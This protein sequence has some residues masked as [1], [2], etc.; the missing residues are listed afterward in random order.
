MLKQ[1][2]FLSLLMSVL[3]Q[4]IG[5]VSVFF[6]A[7]LMGAEALGQFSAAL[8]FAST[9]MVFGDLG[10]GLAH[11]KKVSEG[12]D[13]TKCVGTF[14]RVKITITIILTLL[15]IGII[16]ISAFFFD[17]NVI[18]GKNYLLFAVLFISVIIGNITQIFR[19]TYAALVQKAKEWAS[20]ISVKFTTASL[21][22][23]TAVFGLGVLFLGVSTLIGSIV[24]L[25]IAL[26]YF[27]N[28]TIGKFDKEYFK[29]YTKYAIPSFFIG[30]TSAIALQLDKVFLGWLSEPTQVGYYTAAQS[31]VMIIMF[32]NNIFLGLL[33]PTY[34]K[35]NA[36]GN[37]KG[38]S[39]L[40][41]R[42]ERYIAI[43]LMGF[44]VLFIIFSSPI[45][46]IIFGNKFSDSNYI[47][48]ILVVNAMILVFTQPY[49][50]QLMGLNK[51]NLSTFIS[52]FMLIINLVLYIILVPSQFLGINLFGLEAEGTALS[53]LITNL[54]G[55]LLFRF[56]AFK[57]TNSKPNYRI[58]Q[59][60]VISLILFGGTK[61]IITDYFSI[62]NNF[63]ILIFALVV[64]L[65]YFLI[66]RFF[67][68]LLPSDI[69]FY[70]DTLNLKKLSS[71]VKGELK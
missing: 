19:Y 20:L 62:S 2:S 9:I 56:Y 23:I 31:L 47:I 25:F 14:A 26:Y 49:T 3:Q 8:A 65:I 61:F 69:T 30:F 27:R 53:L 71:Y 70:L 4:L 66:L 45:L 10:Y 46:H 59:Y 24:G 15:V 33:L 39:E 44:G 51:V 21:K 48:K 60:L 64:L 57:F 7:R 12:L 34:S 18:P 42:I 58:I 40:A 32:V 17:I 52:V 35:M 13:V 5:F 28:L 54:I 22:I 38:I 67:K 50:S 37:L 68:M 55:T 6:V 43:P 11:Y 1:K 16:L 41:N 29:S 63:I 36:E